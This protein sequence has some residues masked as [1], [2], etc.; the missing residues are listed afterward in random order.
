M[1]RE[2]DLYPLIKGRS[3]W[4]G[5]INVIAFII[6]FLLAAFTPEIRRQGSEEE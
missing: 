5:L 3:F 1:I 2:T 4:D 6:A